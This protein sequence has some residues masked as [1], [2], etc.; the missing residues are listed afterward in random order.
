[1]FLP[2]AKGRASLLLAPLSLALCPGEVQPWPGRLLLHEWMACRQDC[3][4]ILQVE[5]IVDDCFSLLLSSLKSRGKCPQS[6]CLEKLL[7]HG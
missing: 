3:A 5:E 2:R 7:G 1:M 6:C 4:L